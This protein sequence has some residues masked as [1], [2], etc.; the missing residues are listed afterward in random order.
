[1]GVLCVE[2]KKVIKY[3]IKILFQSTIDEID[4]CSDSKDTTQ[5]VSL[6]DKLTE[7]VFEYL[8]KNSKLKINASKGSLECNI[9]DT[10]E[11]FR[12]VMIFCREV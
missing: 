6:L 11:E 1:M 7:Q 12:F 9:P 10:L 5:C 4:T 3:T 2:A 8:Y